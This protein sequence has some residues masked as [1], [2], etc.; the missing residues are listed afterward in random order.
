MSYTS[1]DVLRN[2]KYVLSVSMMDDGRRINR[3]A[4]E[5]LLIVWLLV[6]PS[7]HFLYF[8]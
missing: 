3:A 4:N 7:I 6:Y 1:E 5:T 2:L 8:S